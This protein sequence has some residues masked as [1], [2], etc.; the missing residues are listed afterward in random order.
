MLRLLLA[1]VHVVPASSDRNNPPFS[2]SMIAY[3]R[4]ASA[5]ETATP[6]FPSTPCGSPGARV[7]SVHVSPPSVDLYNPLP[8]PP[9]DISHSLRYAS[10]IAAYI[11]L[12]LCG[13]IEISTAPVAGPLYNTLRQVLPPSVLLKRPRSSLLTP[14]FPKSATNT[15][16]GSVG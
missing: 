4:F 12:G 5:P 11:T 2:F 9:L 16:F 10:H 13:S 7:M 6:I 8:G 15:M 1:N 14:Y 3:T